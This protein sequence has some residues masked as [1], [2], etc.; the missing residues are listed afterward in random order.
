MIKKIYDENVTLLYAVIKN[1]HRERINAPNAP[2]NLRYHLHVH[3]FQ[4]YNA[5]LP[6]FSLSL[7]FVWNPYLNSAKKVNFAFIQ[8][9]IGTA[10]WQPVY[11]F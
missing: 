7:R 11:G 10:R 9:F 1:A 3:Q 6:T 2:H 8:T 4:E 5:L